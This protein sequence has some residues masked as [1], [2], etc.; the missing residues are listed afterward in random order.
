MLKKTTEKI[1]KNFK[2]AI[3]STKKTIIASFGSIILIVSRYTQY[4]TLT[5]PQATLY[6]SSGYSPD[7]SFSDE[8][9][10]SYSSEASEESYFSEEVEDRDFPE[11]F[12]ELEENKLVAQERENIEKQRIDLENNINRLKRDEDSD[13][14][15][16]SKNL[17]LV[18]LQKKWLYT[19]KTLAE[20][21]LFELKQELLD[22]KP[23]EKSRDKLELKLNRNKG[24]LTLRDHH[25]ICAKSREISLKLFEERKKIKEE[26]YGCED[27]VDV[28][29]EYL[30]ELDSEK[31][32]E[33]VSNENFY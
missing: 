3:N 20:L 11:Y 31:V 6:V 15:G 12:Q 19:N 21:R 1:K 28:V 26:W 18:E 27:D 16:S 7:S 23:L 4:S 9:E 8:S 29:E 22:L 2:A 14:K 25:L 30:D 33:E 13:K 10:D 24:E 5:L 17:E 32:T